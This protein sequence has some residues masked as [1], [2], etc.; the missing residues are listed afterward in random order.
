M[1]GFMAVSGLLGWLNIRG[2][3]VEVRLPDEV[4]AGLETLVTIRIENSKRLLPSFLI[5]ATISGS[6][7]SFILLDP[8]TPEN[9]SLLITFQG[10]GMHG[11]P[12]ALISSPFP[13]QFLRPLH[14]GPRCRQFPGLPGAL[15]LDLQLSGGKPDNGAHPQFVGK[16]IRRGTGENFGLPGRRAAQTDPLAPLREARGLQG[17]GD[18]GYRD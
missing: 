8:R 2:L 18:G 12:E 13:G 17:E 14:Q 4:Y 6:P 5:T 9:G 1:L 15:P 11:V 7:T 3:S 16:R 10:R